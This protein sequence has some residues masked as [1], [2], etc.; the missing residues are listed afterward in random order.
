MSKTRIYYMEITDLNGQQHQIKTDDY[1]NILD[2][3][4]R[5][6]GKIQGVDT[7]S[8]LV[9]EEKLGELKKDK[10]FK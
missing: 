5:Y 6:K 7:G 9:N 1:Q 8:R 2:F 10:N 4:K 3:A